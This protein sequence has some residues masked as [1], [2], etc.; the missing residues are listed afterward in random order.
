[1]LRIYLVGTEASF[2]AESCNSCVSTSSAGNC[3]YRT[4]EPLMK[5]FFTES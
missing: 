4:T 1:M 5:Q 2:L 3:T